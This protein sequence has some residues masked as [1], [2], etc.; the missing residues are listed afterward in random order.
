MN[1]TFAVR[2]KTSS[3]VRIVDDDLRERDLNIILDKE[4]LYLTVQDTR[5]LVYVFFVDTG[6]DLEDHTAVR[7]FLDTKIS[8]IFKEQLGILDLD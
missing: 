5:S 8:G 4:T 2:T 1:F 6:T 3:L 7:E